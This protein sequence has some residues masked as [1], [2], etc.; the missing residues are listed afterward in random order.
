MRLS[1]T[2]L[3]VSLVAGIANA[4]TTPDN[5]TTYTLESLSQISGSGVTVIENG[6]LL[7]ENLQISATDK[8]QLVSNDYLYIADDVEVVIEGEAL[9]NPETTA[10]INRATEEA[11]PN[12]FKMFGKTIIKNM[13][14]Q[15][16]GI[17]Y[18]GEEALTVEDCYFHNINDKRNGFGVIS[19]TGINEGSKIVDTIFK[20]CVTGA[21]NTPVNNGLNLLIEGCTIENV[22]TSNQMR[23]YINVTSPVTGE[24]V[25][26]N[27]TLIG[28]KLEKP[29]GIGV[30]NMMNTPGD[31]KVLIENNTVTDCSFG[32]NFVGGMDVRIIGNNVKSN[33]WDPTDDGGIAVTMYSIQTYPQTVYAEGNTF[34][35]NKWGPCAV[36]GSICNYGKTD[37]PNA[38]DYNPG[39][40]TFINN[41]FTNSANED[42]IC[43]IANST[44]NTLYAQGNIW[45]DAETAE[46]AAATIFDNTVDPAKYGPIVYAPIRTSTGVKGVQSNVAP[47]IDG[48]VEV[49]T[50]DGKLIMKGDITGISDLEPG[51]YIIRAGKMT[52]KIVK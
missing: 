40:N 25:I 20:D 36:V 44:P 48:I 41:H 32:L 22:S 17:L 47:K 51:A 21:I 1:L 45:N 2:F 46:E 18:L 28:A 49:F 33:R 7:S 19:F 39:N 10:Y 23:P 37:D 38:E 9:F 14:I 16:G 29:G 5:G 35:D 34:E 42:V 52:Q 43:D 50:I 13:D 11:E 12:G 26:R 30:S 24:L 15:G 4:Y 27:N 8:L 3:V 31:N 6:Y